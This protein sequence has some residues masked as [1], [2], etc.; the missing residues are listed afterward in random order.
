MSNTITNTSEEVPVETTSEHTTAAPGGESVAAS[1]GLNGTLFVFQLINFAIVA[2]VI[3]FLILK[4]LTSKMAERQKMID[5]SIDN[6]KKIQENLSRG[7]R[8]Y[9]SKIDQ[10]K[11]DANKIIEKAGTEAGEL[12][13]TMKEKAKEEITTLVDQAKRHINVE[14]DEVMAN[15]KSETGNL[16]IAAVEKILN[17]KLDDKKDKNLIEDTLKNLKA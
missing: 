3:W 2:A 9:Q 8:D 12:T 11:V 10:A 15:I 14:R 16:I 13:N 6:A 17:E 1:L 4:P 5:E 7:E